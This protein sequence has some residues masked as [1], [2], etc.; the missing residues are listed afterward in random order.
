MAGTGSAYGHQAGQYPAA[1]P[2]VQGGQDCGPGPQPLPGGGQLIHHHLTRCAHIAAA[3]PSFNGTAGGGVARRSCVLTGS[4]CGRPTCSVWVRAPVV[5]TAGTPNYMAP[6]LLESQVG[7]LAHPHAV[8]IY[9]C[10]AGPWFLPFPSAELRAALHACSFG[11]VLHEVA[12]GKAPELR[13]MQPLR[14]GSWHVIP[15]L[16]LSPPQGTGVKHVVT[17]DRGA[18]PSVTACRTSA[19]KASR[20][21]DDA[22]PLRIPPRGPAPARCWRRWKPWGLSSARPSRKPSMR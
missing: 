12:S 2:D 6:E 8:D 17:A 3:V 4:P 5:W 13:T 14:Y 21:W 10:G 11:V 15:R 18:G 22:V 20:T 9:R 7:K 16:F 1:R 19:L